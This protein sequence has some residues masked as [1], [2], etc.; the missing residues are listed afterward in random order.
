MEGELLGLMVKE[1]HISPGELTRLSCPTL[2]I[3]G[4]R[5]L[6]RESHTRLMAASIPDAQLVILPGDHFIANK[7]SAAFNEKVEAFFNERRG[8]NEYHEAL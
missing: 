2:V 3:A 6:I 4:E 7:Q 1:P 5:D 8:Q